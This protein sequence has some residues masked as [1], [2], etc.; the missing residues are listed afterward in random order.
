MGFKGGDFLTCSSPTAQGRD[1]GTSLPTTSSRTVSPHDVLIST[2]DSISPPFS[3][4]SPD[5][6]G[7]SADCLGSSD[8]DVSDHGTCFFL[9][10]QD[11][12]ITKDRS[13]ATYHFLALQAKDP[14]AVLSQSPPHCSKSIS[15]SPKVTNGHDL[16]SSVLADSPRQ[17][18][19]RLSPVNVKDA[20]NKL[21]RKRALNNRCAREYRE[22]K[23][24]RLECLMKK[25][26]KLEKE[27]AQWK[28]IARS[29]LGGT[30]N[31]FIFT[32]AESSPFRTYF[33]ETI[34]NPNTSVLKDS[35]TR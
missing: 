19:R 4:E 30:T 9:S 14:G 24:Y 12:T 32:D 22:R 33:G 35:S 6:T 29:L 13:T 18:N 20:P 8:V 31:T 23:A 17:R 26:G 2:S 3:G 5:A 7:E 1:F 34:G 16:H 27:C 28:G 15:N 21:Q 10:H 11:N 25:V